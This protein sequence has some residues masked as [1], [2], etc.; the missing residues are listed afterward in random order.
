MTKLSHK[1]YK[2]IAYLLSGAIFFMMTS[3]DE[4]MS[5]TT[6]NEKLN[7]PSQVINNANIIQRDSGFVTMRAK[8]PIIEKYQLIDSPYTVARKGIDIEFFDRKKPDKPGNIKAKY[9]K[10]YDLKKFYEAR[11]NVRITTNENQRFAMQSVFW[12]QV[13][14]EIFTKDTVYVTLEDGSTLVYSKGMWAKDDFSEYIFY[15]GTGEMN[16]K[17][18]NEKVKQ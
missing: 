9:A 18:L 17:R 11:G 14:K 10:F 16:A 13:K 1:I 15:K 3:C 2:H 4:D 5:K 6:A 12:D 7:F 8:A